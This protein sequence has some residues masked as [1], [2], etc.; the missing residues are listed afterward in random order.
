MRHNK[1][2]SAF[3][4]GLLLGM[5]LVTVMRAIFNRGMP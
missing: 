1:N 2:S 5:L 4:Y 3:A